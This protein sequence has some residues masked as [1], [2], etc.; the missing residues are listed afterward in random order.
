MIE[1]LTTCFGGDDEDMPEMRKK[2]GRK[3]KKEGKGKGKGK[4][5]GEKCPK[6]DDLLAYMFDDVEGKGCVEKQ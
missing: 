2:G 3:G 4:N 5:K 1:A 6:A